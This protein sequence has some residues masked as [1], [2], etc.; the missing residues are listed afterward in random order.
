M[1]LASSS[2]LSHTPSRVRKSSAE[3]NDLAFH[4]SSG[5]AGVSHLGHFGRGVAASLLALERTLTRQQAGG[6]TARFF[7]NSARM[8]TSLHW[9]EVLRVYNSTAFALCFVVLM[10]TALVALSFAIAAV[11]TGSFSLTSASWQFVCVALGGIVVGYFVG[12]AAM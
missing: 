6:Y 5:T 4:T 2:G 11:Q 8:R 1:S 12:M 7:Q 9:A 3:C 10:V